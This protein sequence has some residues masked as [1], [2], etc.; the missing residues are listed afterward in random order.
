MDAKRRGN[1]GS[2]ARRG[3][4]QAGRHRTE[5]SGTSETPEEEEEEEGEVGGWWKNFV[6]NFGSVELE[7]KG[8][9]ARDHLALGRFVLHR[10]VASTRG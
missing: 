8:S 9:V 5:T 4:S 2:R 1:R 7:N 3:G 6:E 10:V